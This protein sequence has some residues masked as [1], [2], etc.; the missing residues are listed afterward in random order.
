MQRICKGRDIISS[1][2]KTT[3]LDA[4]EMQEKWTKDSGQDLVLSIGS[5]SYCPSWRPNR[6]LDDPSRQDISYVLLNTEF[7]IISK[8]KMKYAY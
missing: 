7:E 8:I 3:L 4:G 5:F 2:S 6:G 1:T